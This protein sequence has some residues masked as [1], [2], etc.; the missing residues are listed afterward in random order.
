VEFFSAVVQFY[1]CIW[2]VIGTT[3]HSLWTHRSPC[4]HFQRTHVSKSITSPSK[5]WIKTGTLIVSTIATVIFEAIYHQQS[6][7]YFIS[8]HYLA[9]NSWSKPGWSNKFASLRT[10]ASTRWK[11]ST[12]RASSRSGRFT[13]R[14]TVSKYLRVM[15]DWKSKEN[16][17]KRNTVKM[18]NFFTSSEV[19]K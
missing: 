2:S 16:E 9:T 12:R 1:H 19:Y 6:C 14:S 17:A 18:Q 13:R 3:R 15:W 11:G 10:S 8:H 7:N 5:V 4:A